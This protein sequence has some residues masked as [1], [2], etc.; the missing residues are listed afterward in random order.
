MR[1]GI[2]IPFDEYT[3]L[4]LQ[5]WEDPARTVIA[6]TAQGI[7]VRLRSSRGIVR[8]GAAGLE[9]SIYTTPILLRP[10]LGMELLNKWKVTLDGPRM[11]MNVE[12]ST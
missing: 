2:I 4:G 1:E 11:V 10:L 6:R 12:E 7:S 8:L 3:T 5:G 9:C